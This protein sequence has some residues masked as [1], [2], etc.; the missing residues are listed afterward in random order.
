MQLWLEEMKTATQR[1]SVASSFTRTHAISP[2]PRKG[3]SLKGTSL[4][5]PWPVCVR[6]CVCVCVC[7]C[8]RGR[9]TDTQS[10]RE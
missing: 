3:V 5:P 8:V 7:V 4:V 2:E 1:R 6:V 10:E 9:K